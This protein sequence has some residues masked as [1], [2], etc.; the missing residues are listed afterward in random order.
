MAFNVKKRGK[1]TYYYHGDHPVPCGFVLLLAADSEKLNTI[2]QQQPWEILHNDSTC[3]S[4]RFADGT[5][6]A[7]F[8]EPQS[9]GDLKV[10]KPSLALWKGTSRRVIDLP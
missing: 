3:Q 9:I 6:T 2:S 5:T 8:Y 10:D 1:L 7:A 4:I